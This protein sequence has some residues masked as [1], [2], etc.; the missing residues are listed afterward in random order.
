MLDLFR[1][2]LYDA[3]DF[4]CCRFGLLGEFAHFFGDNNKAGCRPA[5]V[6]ENDGERKRMTGKD[7]ARGP[8]YVPR[9]AGLLMS[10]HLR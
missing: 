2:F 10:Q 1:V 5:S 3:A 4:L 8:R 7:S 6:P 9:P